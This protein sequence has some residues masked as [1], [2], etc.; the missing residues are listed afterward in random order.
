MS[1]EQK[2]REAFEARMTDNGKWPDAITKGRNGCYL[3]AQ[4]ENAWAEW[5]ACAEALTLPTTEPSDGGVGEWHAPGLG[6][7]HHAD[8]RSLIYCETENPE[9]QPE[10]DDGLARHVC[11]LLNAQTASQEQA[12]WAEYV[13][14]MVDHW[15][16]SEEY[17]SIKTDDDRCIKAIAG[18]IERRIWALKREPAPEPTTQAQEPFGY[19]RP[20]P[21]G[22]TNCDPTDEG[23][24]ALYE[25]PAADLTDEQIRDVFKDVD[26]KRKTEG[27]T[28][29]FEMLNGS[30]LCGDYLDAITEASRAIIA[31]VKGVE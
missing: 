4:T 3:L 17:A 28:A 7:V 30:V 15:V 31:K 5:R 16:R 23:A 11:S 27:K 19:F 26:V 1:N 10:P 25:H 14:G 6:E 21:F 18:I 12:K 8:H 2:L 20:E 29:L 9:G 22:W 24:I 13:A